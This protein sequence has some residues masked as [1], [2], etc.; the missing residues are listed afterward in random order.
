MELPAIETREISNR[1][2]KDL[3]GI[4]SGKVA[5]KY[6]WVSKVKSHISALV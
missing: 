2:K 6:G 5:D 4:K 1:L 3:E